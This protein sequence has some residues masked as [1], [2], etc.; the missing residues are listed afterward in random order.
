MT[1][2]EF[3][4]HIRRVITTK[5]GGKH[6]LVVDIS[7]S[8]RKAMQKAITTDD[9]PT[10]FSVNEHGEVVTWVSV[11]DVNEH[12]E[13]AVGAELNLNVVMQA[14]LQHWEMAGKK[15]WGL[16]LVNYVVSSGPSNTV[17]RLDG[18]EAPPATY[19]NSSSSSSSTTPKRKAAV[20][21][22][23]EPPKAP[24]K[25]R[26]PPAAVHTSS[27]SS[28]KATPLSSR[29][30]DMGDLEDYTDGDEEWARAEAPEDDLGFTQNIDLP[31][32]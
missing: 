27:S 22:E 10:P 21:R 20:T 13:L 30:L 25:P 26:Q 6:K 4:A 14:R 1:I 24:K 2:F 5:V 3:K 23:R 17:V 28:S 18:L 8:A 9:T 12:K 29:K 7:E 15:G 16:Y 11:K 32:P 19:A 31:S